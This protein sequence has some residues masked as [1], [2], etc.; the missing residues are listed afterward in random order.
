MSSAARVGIDTAGS[1]LILDGSTSVFVG[2]YLLATKGSNV[3]S[4]SP[5]HSFVTVIEGSSSVFVEG[6]EVARIGDQA[7]CGHLLI[8]GDESVSIG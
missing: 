8:G 7:S 1:G 4:H 6:K 3:A 5:G 2:E